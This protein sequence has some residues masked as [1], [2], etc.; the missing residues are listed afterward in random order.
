MCERLP[1]KFCQG[2]VFV[3]PHPSMRLPC[4]RAGLGPLPFSFCGEKTWRVSFPANLGPRFVGIGQLTLGVR[5][6]LAPQPNRQKTQSVPRCPPLGLP[7]RV[8]SK[9][10]PAGQAAQGTEALK[11][12][13]CSHSQISRRGISVGHWIVGGSGVPLHNGGCCSP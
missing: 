4:Q 13:D 2:R 12:E 1:K 9:A 3:S 10:A 5:G 6:R 7:F 11:T 8:S